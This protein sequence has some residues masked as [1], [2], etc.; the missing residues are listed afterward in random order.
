M[1][2]HTTAESIIMPA[3]KITVG[4]TTGKAAESETDKV[5][6]CDNSVGRRVGGTSE[7]LQKY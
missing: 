6:V 2:S 5:P 7:I 4:T 3:C 1:K